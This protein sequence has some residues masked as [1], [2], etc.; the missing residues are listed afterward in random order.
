M[1]TTPKDIITSAQNPLVKR[2]RKLTKGSK[3][4]LIDQQT[5]LDGIHLCQSYLAGQSQPAICVVSSSGQNNSEVIDLMSDIDFNTKLFVTSDELFAT[6]SPVKHSAGILFVIDTPEQSNDLFLDSDA[7]LLDAVQ[8]SGNVGTLLRTAAAAGVKKVYLSKGS[9]SAWSPQVLRAG[10]GAHFNLDIF[11]QV[12]LFALV[13]KSKVPVYGTSLETS[14]SLY[15]SKFGSPAAWIFG[16]EGSGVNPDLLSK[17][18]QTFFIPQT[19]NVESLNVSAS[20][21]VCLFEQRRQ[22]LLDAS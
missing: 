13:T 9:A 22:R 19:D 21:A 1:D 12:D 16:N 17:C 14:K 4:R 11:E 5:I 2:L 7:L 3:Q 8:D 20:A 18:N 6:F 15:D 10:M